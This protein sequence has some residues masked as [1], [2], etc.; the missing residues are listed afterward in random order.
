MKNNWNYEKCKEEALKY[1][2][3]KDFRREKQ[4]AYLHAT[5]RGFLNEICSHMKL[6]GN[7][8]KRC[9]Y[10]YEFPDNHVYIGLTYDINKRDIQHNYRNDSSVFNHSNE[11]GLYPTLIQLTDYINI[12]ES[13]I[14]E[15]TKIKEYEN[16][17]FIILNKAKPGALGG[18]IIKWTKEECLKF[19]LTCKTT[20]EFKT[21]HPNIYDA[22]IRNKWLR[23]VCNHME[24]CKPDHYWSKEL[25]LVEALKFSNKRDF[26]NKGNAA[27]IAARRNNWMDEITT[28]MVEL[29]KP[30]GYWTKL[31]CREEASKY[32][33]RK[34][35]SDKSGS[36]YVIARQNGWLNDIC[37]HMK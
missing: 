28:H 10:A 9:I 7:L 24:M 1:E 35:F 22:C 15:E 8:Y 20:K 29:I 31:K 18:V 4:G 32:T 25:C 23:E 19:S 2:Y 5:R 36:A 17:G 21:K 37:E 26:Q 13:V 16:K 27:F 34:E 12:E 14:M 30:K 3:R 33:K 6:L 11:T